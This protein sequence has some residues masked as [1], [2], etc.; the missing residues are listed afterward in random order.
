MN[1]FHSSQRLKITHRRVYAVPARATPSLPPKGR[2]GSQ[3][4]QNRETRPMRM[5]SEKAIA[6][7]LAVAISGTAFNTF[8]V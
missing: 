4:Q 2:P 5:I 8:I 6:F 7:L 3:P 1:Y